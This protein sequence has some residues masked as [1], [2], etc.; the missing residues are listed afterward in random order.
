MTLSG[1]SQTHLNDTICCVSCTSLRN[2][3]KINQENIYNKEYNI[4]LKNQIN[5]YKRIITIQDSLITIRQ[6]QLDILFTKEENLNEIIKEYQK[7]NKNLLLE[8]KKQKT[9]TKIILISGGILL[10]TS[11]LLN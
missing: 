7:Y 3:L 9:K 10:I 5:G 8:N 11:L 1:N 6:N 2:A 4:F